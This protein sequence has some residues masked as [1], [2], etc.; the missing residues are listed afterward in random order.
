MPVPI[1][2]QCG[3]GQRYSFDVEPISNRMPTAVACPSCGADGTVAAN[4]ILAQRV[5]PQAV[6]AVPAPVPVAAVTTPGG[7]SAM[8]IA[9]AASSVHRVSQA[10]VVRVVPT[11]TA[12][13][14]PVSAP[15]ER[16]KLPGQMEPDRAQKEARSKILWGDEPAE[17]TRFLMSQGFSADEADD[18]IAPVLAERA[19]AI[20]KAGT[21]K[22]FSGIGMIMVPIVTFLVMLSAGYLNIKI[23]GVTVAIGLWGLS[24]GISGAI[25]LISPKS[26]K[27][28]VGDM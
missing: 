28:D 3:C 2:L 13:S 1:K 14:A 11:Q 22:L 9:A 19:D 17:V 12:P 10:A 16:K 8:Q 26:E 4:A 27:G 18:T 7:V 5:Q 20:R 25:M 24:R 21:G 6:I 15:V 23:L